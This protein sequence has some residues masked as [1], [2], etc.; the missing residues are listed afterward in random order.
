MVCVYSRLVVRS[1]PI[2]FQLHRT[3][4]TEVPFIHS[5]LHVCSLQWI[6]ARDTDELHGNAHAALA[7]KVEHNMVT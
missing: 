2:I 5:D 3:K 4:L 1:D 7:H 6:I